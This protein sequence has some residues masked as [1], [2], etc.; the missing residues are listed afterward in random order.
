MTPAYE[1]ARTALALL[2]EAIRLGRRTGEGRLAREL[3]RA[4]KHLID[5]L[6]VR[7]AAGTPHDGGLLVRRPSQVAGGLLDGEILK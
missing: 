4:Q 7:P 2:S 1:H 6:E 5:A 3:Q